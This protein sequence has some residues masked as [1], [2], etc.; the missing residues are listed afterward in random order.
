MARFGR[1]KTDGPVAPTVIT[2]TLGDPGGDDRLDVTFRISD[3]GVRLMAGE[4]EIGSWPLA[5]VSMTAGGST[6]WYF[7]A[8]GDRLPFVPTRPAALEASA[9]VTRP[10][11]SRRS[12][13]WSG[14]R[15]RPDPPATPEPD[16]PQRADV[17]PE[18][19]GIGDR[20]TA[21][22]EP[23]GGRARPHPRKPRTRRMPRVSNPLRRTP[24]SEKPGERDARER[25]W[26][27]TV[28]AARRRGW[29]GLD[30]LPVDESDRHGPHQHT[31]DHP[32]AASSGPA[33]HVCTICGAIR[34]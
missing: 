33:Q 11:G 14:R 30:R 6:L 16:R 31:W 3:D 20:A 7:E 23:P 19:E 4:R 15:R 10:D 1:R 28:D 22:A 9:L 29:F 32:A 8:E 17:P 26:L 13:P 12:R 27:R 25:L 24:G 5:D 2:G 21:S 34:R 18:R